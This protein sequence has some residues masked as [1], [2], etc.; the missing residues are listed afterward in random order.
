MLA[1]WYLLIRQRTGHRPPLALL[2]RAGGAIAAALA[3]FVVI[4]ASYRFS[5]EPL[6]AVAANGTDW[7]R[8]LWGPASLLNNAVDAV[9][10]LPLPATGFVRGIQAVYRH[11]EEGHWSYLLGDVRETGWWYFFPV[12]LLVK[13][14]LPTLLLAAIGASVLIR[15]SWRE[16]RW[17]L[18][19][20]PLSMLAFA[21]VLL[22]SHITIGVRHALPVYCFMAVA[23]G[24]GAAWLW[25][26]LRRCMAGPR[27]RRPAV[28]LAGGRRARLAPRLH[29]LFQRTRAAAP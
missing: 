4:W 23:A 6:R 7:S 18:A 29:R 21:P 16:R 27:P 20:A 12:A 24:G 14:P 17:S 15:R 25:N 28:R 19:A 22:A 2:R 1:A 9:V 13:T 5:L 10:T 8:R 11:N 26:G 3:V